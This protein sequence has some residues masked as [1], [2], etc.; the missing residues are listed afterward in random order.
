MK[1]IYSVQSDVGISKEVNQDAVAFKT[2]KTSKGNAIF[3]VLCDGMGGYDKGEVASASV[4]KAFLKWFDDDFPKLI[5]DYSFE[6][7]KNQWNYTIQSINGKIINYGRSC[8]IDLGTTLTA[9]LIFDN[10]YY[11]CHVGD[12]RIYLIRNKEINQ[13]TQDHTLVAKMLEEHKITEDELE[14]HPDR[15]VLM[16]CIGASRRVV[17][18]FEYAKVATDDVFLLCSDGFRHEITRNEIV[19]LLNHEAINTNQEISANISRLIER[20]EMRQEEDNITVAVIK[21]V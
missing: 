5:D 19:E 15:N 14:T 6:D 17:P 10:N 13:I 20:A 18:Q 11:F 4:V 1:Y 21:I 8:G 16:Q 3:C 2:V 9:I 7:I 12:S